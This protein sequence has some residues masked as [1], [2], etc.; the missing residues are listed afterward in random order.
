MNKNSSSAETAPAYRIVY[1]PAGISSLCPADRTILADAASLGLA[2]RSDC[3]GKG[4]CGQ[5]KVIVSAH[6]ALAEPSEDE[7]Q[8]LTKREL[9]HGYRLAC[10]LRPRTPLRVTIPETSLDSPEAGGKENLTG[11]GKPDPSVRRRVVSPAGQEVVADQGSD[12][13]GLIQK[14]QLPTGWNPELTFSAL[15]HLSRCAPDRDL[16]LIA[17]QRFGVTTILPGAHLRSVGMAF[18]LGT[19][20]LAA[21]LCDFFH[22]SVLA[23]ASAANPQRRF[24]EDVVSRIASA[25]ET[26]QGTETM[27]ALVVG[28]M[29]QLIGM[30]LEQAECPLA[31]L[32]E[33]CVVGNPTMQHLFLGLSPDALGSYPYRPVTHQSIDVRSADVGLSTRPEVNVHVFPVVSG[34]IGGD[35]IAAV[36]ADEVHRRKEITLLIDI[37]TNGELVLGNSERLWATSCA[38]GPALEGA[39]ISCGMRAVSGAIDKVVID[40]NTYQPDT[41]IIGNEK[42]DTVPIG[43]CGSGIIDVVAEMVKTGVILPNGRLRE[44]LPRVLQD[45][46]GIGKGFLIWEREKGDSPPK[47]GDSPLFLSDGESRRIVLSLADIRH[48]QLAKAALAAGIHLLMKRSGHDRFD[49]LVLT[50]AFGARFNWKNAII[51]GML[52]DAADGVPVEIIENGAGLGA[53]KALL[54]AAQ[55]QEKDRLASSISF[56]DLSSDPDFTEIFTASTIF[57]RAEP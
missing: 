27:Q 38:T 42:G 12:L 14:H 11:T 46:Q 56:L 8:L 37:G 53:V 9:R 52:P 2:L 28:A 34:F 29:N 25:R 23:A 40:P 7:Q 10:F 24:G 33:M 1:E 30:C 31:S 3:G 47:K 21:Y 39:H 20:T 55:R 6:E 16:T 48:V 35:T 50:G 45:D 5:C 22:G 54:N 4:R 18:D 36:L 17:H 26:E 44:G 13:A 41:H 32:D 49:R 51:I 19:T 43:L 15:L 57:S